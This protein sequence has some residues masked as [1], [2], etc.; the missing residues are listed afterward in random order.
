MIHQNDQNKRHPAHIKVRVE[1]NLCATVNEGV[2]E[3]SPAKKK[4]ETNCEFLGIGV[5]TNQMLS[6]VKSGVG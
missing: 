3:W 1:S 2:Q 6:E 5:G 4:R